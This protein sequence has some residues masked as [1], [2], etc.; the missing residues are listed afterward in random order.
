MNKIFLKALT[1]IFLV[2]TAGIALSSTGNV[3]VNNTPEPIVVTEYQCRK[4]NIDC[5]V[6]KI[7]YIR[8]GAIYYD[9]ECNVTDINKADY[10]ADVINDVQTN[11]FHYCSK[12]SRTVKSGTTLPN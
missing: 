8:N 1:I 3:Y 10:E 12:I 6:D 9:A 5:V 11:Y 2:S 7:K 4:S